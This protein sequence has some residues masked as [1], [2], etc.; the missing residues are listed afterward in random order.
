MT[1]DRRCF[2]CGRT[3]SEHP[4]S[5]APSVGVSITIRTGAGCTRYIPTPTHLKGRP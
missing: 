4:A 1:D 2:W 3:E 5:R